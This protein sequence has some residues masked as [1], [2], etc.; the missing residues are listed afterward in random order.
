MNFLRASA[1][2]ILFFIVTVAACISF[3]PAF[4][5]PRKGFLFFIRTYLSMVRMLEYHVLG[6]RYEVRGREHLPKRGSFIVA[7]KHQSAYE[8]MKIPELL[9][10]PVI[11]MKKEILNLPLWG[12]FVKKF[13]AITIDRA[14]K[15]T[16][17]KA[18]VDASRDIMAQGRPII[19]FPQGTRV[20]PGQDA[21]EKPYKG[22]V[23]RMQEAT[24]LPIVPLALNSGVYWPRSGW[25]KKP[26]TVIFQYLEPI[27]AGLPPREVT[28]LLRDRLEAASDALI[29]EANA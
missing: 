23:A 22:G 4:L 25:M 14:D 6:L 11:I 3:M 10:E 9:G 26:G 2:N 24:G 16:A 15:E 1:F 12:Q 28:L 27:P 5:L 19:I 29:R 7:S 8:T 17:A 13:G 18:L 21:K 20:R